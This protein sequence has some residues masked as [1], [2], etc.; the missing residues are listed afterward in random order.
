MDAAERS[1]LARASHRHPPLV[2]KCIQ[3]ATYLFKDYYT[4]KLII[5]TAP[6]YKVWT[7]LSLTNLVSV[8]NAVL[9][10]M[11]D[12]GLLQY[13]VTPKQL[14]TSLSL[15]TS[16]HRLRWAEEQWLLG[17]S[18]RMRCRGCCSDRLENPTVP[19]FYSINLS[20]AD[21]YT[22]THT[23]THIRVTVY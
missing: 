23:Y 11:T 21:M 12:V 3:A 6:F 4:S 2:D 10:S 8:A 16:S 13:F 22:R 17:N 9:E 20:S 15:S 7:S 1:L 14:Q 19:C 18:G 5:D